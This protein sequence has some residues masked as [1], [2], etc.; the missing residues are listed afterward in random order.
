M[1][2]RFAQ[3]GFGAIRKLSKMAALITC[4]QM[5]YVKEQFTSGLCYYLQVFYIVCA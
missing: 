4:K 1:I 5:V 2:Y 3:V